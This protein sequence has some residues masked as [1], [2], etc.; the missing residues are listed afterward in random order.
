MTKAATR[1]TTQMEC[2]H[3]PLGCANGFALRETGLRHS[4]PQ[5]GR[6]E[7]ASLLGFRRPSGQG[8]AC[9]M[10]GGTSAR[11]LDPRVGRTMYEFRRQDA[12]DVAGTWA[13]HDRNGARPAFCKNSFVDRVRCYH[14]ERKAIRVA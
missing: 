9:V 3:P 4:P 12:G 1:V 2:P 5:G 7:Q 8:S 13:G 6:W 10:A 11:G 14:P